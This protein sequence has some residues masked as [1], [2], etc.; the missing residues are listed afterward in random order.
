MRLK[1]WS[2]NSRRHRELDE[3][4]RFEGRTAVS[5]PARQRCSAR[6]LLRLGDSFRRRQ[7]LC[8]RTNSQ[9]TPSQ[10]SQV[11]ALVNPV[12]EQV[13]H[14]FQS[15]FRI[16]RP[17]LPTHRFPL[18]IRPHSPLM[19]VALCEGVPQFVHRATGFGLGFTFGIVH[20]PDASLCPGQRS[21][22]PHGRINP[23]YGPP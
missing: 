22:G 8:V 17:F 7:R 1:R 6:C 5:T 23:V 9:P 4:S 21:G 14:S 2:H 12:T 11:P 15:V 10:R 13:G 18:T 20:F 19:R 16:V 3:L